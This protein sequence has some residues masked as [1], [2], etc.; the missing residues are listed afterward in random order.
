M[1]VSRTNQ[2]GKAVMAFSIDTPAPATLVAEFLAEGF[3]EA[4]FIRLP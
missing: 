4:R 1:A 3:D 2:G